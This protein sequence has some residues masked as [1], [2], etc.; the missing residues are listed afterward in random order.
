MLFRSEVLKAKSQS[1]LGPIYLTNPMASWAMPLTAVS[2]V[3]VG[4]LF[5]SSGHYTRKESVSGQ[6]VP[7]LGLLTVR[8]PGVGIVSNL[9]VREGDHVARGDV[10]AEIVDDKSSA[11]LGNTMEVIQ[12]QLEIERAQLQSSIRANDSLLK[13]KESALETKITS[14]KEKFSLLNTQK[15]IEQ[16]QVNSN[17][18]LF[19]NIQPLLAKHYVSAFQNEE[20]RRA[21]LS[22]KQRLSSLMEDMAGVKEQINSA[23]HDLIQLPLAAERERGVLE[24]QL[25]AL[26]Q[27]MAKN[28]QQRGAVVRAQSNGI[29][30]SV[31]V[32][33]GQPVSDGKQ[34]LTIIPD[35]SVLEAK[36]YVP[37]SAVGFI[38]KGSLVVIRY[39]AFPYEQYGLQYGRVVNVSSSTVDL[40]DG[41]PVK[42]DLR[43]QPLYLVIVKLEKAYV[44]V[45]GSRFPLRSGMTLDAD[46]LL[47]RR[48]LWDWIVDPFRMISDRGMEG[49]SN[50]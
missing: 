50:G 24:Q 23:N 2:V 1:W 28:E 25:D 18:R 16:E 29:A 49:A 46:I 9:Y 42:K 15:N 7:N 47:D 14:L 6:L 45:G 4:I 30:S 19:L 40:S 36:L 48:S 43:G 38:K 11:T 27:A 35:D 33:K 3:I 37:S 31:L 5:L 41:D 32:K 34:L 13:D 26:Q 39:Q 10:L 44:A 12:A 21:T 8:A 17:Q 22:A 20:Q